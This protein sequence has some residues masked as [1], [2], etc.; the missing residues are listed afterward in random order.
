MRENELFLVDELVLVCTLAEQVMQT[1]A[2]VL[3]LVSCG[4]SCLGMVIGKEKCDPDRLAVYRIVLDTHW[5]RDLFPKQYP[6]V[7][8]PAQ[9]SKLVGRC[10]IIRILLHFI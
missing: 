7:R 9:W 5:S 6:E 3:V 4:V 8:P 1:F 2:V 10:T